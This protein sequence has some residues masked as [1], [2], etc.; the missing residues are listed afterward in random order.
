M[1]TYLQNHIYENCWFCENTNSSFLKE[2]HIVPKHIS[3]KG[4]ELDNLIQDICSDIPIYVTLLN[5]QKHATR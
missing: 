4:R 3:K 2:A 5:K 1:R